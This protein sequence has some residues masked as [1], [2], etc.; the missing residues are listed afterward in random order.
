MMTIAAFG[1]IT[2]KSIGYLNALWLLR[3]SFRKVEAYWTVTVISPPN[4]L[5]QSIPPVF[6]IALA[7]GAA[8]SQQ[9]R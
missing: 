5:S 6:S 4:L 9:A 7:Q 3:V 8:G 2:P 1:G